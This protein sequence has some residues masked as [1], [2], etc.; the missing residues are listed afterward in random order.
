MTSP[1]HAAETFGVE[2][3]IDPWHTRPLLIQWAE[4]AQPAPVLAPVSKETRHAPLGAMHSGF[5]RIGGRRTKKMK[6]RGK[7][8][9]Y[10]FRNKN[11][12]GVKPF[13]DRFGLDVLIQLEQVVAEKDWEKLKSFVQRYG[14]EPLVEYGMPVGGEGVKELYEISD[15]YHGHKRKTAGEWWLRDEMEDVSRQLK[16]YGAEPILQEKCALAWKEVDASVECPGPVKENAFRKVLLWTLI[17]ALYRPE[18]E[19]EQ[20][21]MDRIFGV[22]EQMRFREG[23]VYDHEFSE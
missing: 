11:W 9:D 8:I 6:Y 17:E 7:E 16:G 13:T 15:R 12:E 21:I 2:Q 23:L 22:F 3:I 5:V 14:I 4:K 20:K 19:E 18:S 10:L 1:F